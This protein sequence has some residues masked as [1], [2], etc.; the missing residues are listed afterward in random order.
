MTVAD[1]DSLMKKN[2]IIV[3][4]LATANIPSQIENN[5]TTAEG[6]RPRII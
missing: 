6:L 5:K 3:K 1:L 4:A 2:S